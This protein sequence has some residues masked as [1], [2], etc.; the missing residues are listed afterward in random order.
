MRAGHGSGFRGH[1][2]Q[3][4]YHVRSGPPKA[5]ALGFTVD[6]KMRVALSAFWRAHRLPVAILVAI[7]GAI[8]VAYFL[9]SPKA[10]IEFDSQNTF[11][12]PTYLGAARD[13]LQGHVFSVGR[14]PVYPLLLA[15]LGATSGFYWFVLALQIRLMEV[16]GAARGLGAASVHAALNAANALGAW[17]GGIV[18]AGGW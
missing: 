10:E 9:N 16:A 3:L 13:I 14:L 11:G 12:T 4:G 6:A 7:A 2:S 18:I 1:Q 5:S 17:L 8:L 15:V